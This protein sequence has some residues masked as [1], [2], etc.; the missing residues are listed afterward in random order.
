MATCTDCGRSEYFTVTGSVHKVRV[1]KD[2]L[3]PVCVEIYAEAAFDRKERLR[4]AREL[5]ARADAK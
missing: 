3:C 2:G 1:N 4:E 5:V